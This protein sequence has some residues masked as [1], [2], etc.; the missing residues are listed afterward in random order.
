MGAAVQ[1]PL[2]R[3]SDY[4]A[5]RLQDDNEALMPH[6]YQIFTESHYAYFITCTVANWRPIFTQAPYRQIV[7]DSLNYLRKHKRTQLNAYVIM[8]THLHAVMWPEEGVNES[9]VLRD[10]KRFTSRSISK[11]ALRLGDQDALSTFA[12]ARASSRAQDVS[13]FQVWQEGSHAEA[14]FTFKFAEQKI[15]Y[16]HANP[17]R[18]GLATSPEEWPCSSARAYLCGEETYPPTDVLLP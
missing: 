7:L 18:A 2:K 3:I 12:G 8:P 14:I 15:N 16:I 5:V 1:L 13:Q 11:E 4:P 10:F 17:V 6:A 9:D